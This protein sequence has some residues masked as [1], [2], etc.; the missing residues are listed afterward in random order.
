MDSGFAQRVE[1]QRERLA[2]KPLREIEAAVAAKRVQW[3][4]QRYAA[5]TRRTWGRRPAPRTAFD[6]FFFEYMGLRTDDLRVLRA[7]DREI[8]WSSQNFCPTLEACNRLGLDTRVVCRHAYEKSTQ[9]FVSLTDPAL[10][11]LRDYNQIRPQPTACQERIVRVDFEEMTQI[12]IQ[13]AKQSQ[14]SGN[15]GYGAVVA[16]GD[17]ILARAHDTAVTEQDPSCHAEVNAIRAAV[18]T[19]G[20]SNLS[21]A[22]LFASCEPCPM[23]SSLAVWA[24]LSAMVFGASIEKTAAQGRT[25]IQ[26]AAREIVAR[27]PVQMEISP[28]VLEKECLELYQ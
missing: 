6:M 20:D 1:A 21:G 13:E 8:V 3:F 15:K 16:A 26:V 24:N 4:E 27:S 22:V 17:Q 10:R 28:G 12:A 18:H 23:C 5:G 7:N 2:T 14:R 9:A 19:L 11:F 25:R